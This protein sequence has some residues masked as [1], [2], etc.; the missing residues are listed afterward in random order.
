[1]VCFLYM[2]ACLLYGKTLQ[3]SSIVIVLSVIFSFASGQDA[4]NTPEVVANKAVKAW[5]DRAEKFELDFSRFFTEEPEAM[6]EELTDFGQMPNLIKVTEVNFDDTNVTET[7]ETT[8]TYTYASKTR[9][10]LLGKVIVKLEL[11]NSGEWEAK[12]V[13]LDFSSGA[14]SPLSQLN[15][16]TT[17]WVF[18]FLSFYL[19][20]LCLKPSFFRRW[21]TKG[22]EVIREH[23]RIV[24]GTVIAL[25][26]AFVL[27]V[28]TGQT[29]PENCNAYI[30]ETLS[31]GTN[32]IGI[33]EIIQTGDIARIAAAITFWNF[34][35][36]AIITTLLPAS[37]FAVPA[38]IL[39]LLRFFYLAIPFAN[40]PTQ[41]LTLHLPVIIIELLAYI[42]ITAGGGIFLATLIRKGWKGYREGLRKLFLMVPIA[43][44]LLVI[45]AWYESFE[46]LWLLSN[47]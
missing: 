9:E 20:Y 33:I 13:R 23:K 17:S 32:D 12:T 10:S 30:T 36:G 8:R 42:L 44:V 16:P 3:L 39:N 27:G 29:M 24:L 26:S 18:L 34:S 5:L 21:L 35:M 6:C 41:T 45:G 1:M 46:V 38:Y 7:S 31:Q 4:A 19:L 28:L 47:R 2:K 15:N 43:L 22:I 37:L 11:T 14:P 25:Y 40:I